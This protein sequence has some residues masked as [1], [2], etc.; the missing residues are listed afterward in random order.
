VLD[1]LRVGCDLTVVLLEVSQVV[2]PVDGGCNSISDVES[3]Q[4]SFLALEKRT[5]GFSG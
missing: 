5:L 4:R 2:V 3:K 1:R